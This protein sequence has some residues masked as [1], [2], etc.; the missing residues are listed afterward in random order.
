MGATSNEQP[1]LEFSLEWLPENFSAN[2]SLY[3]SCR[4]NGS[5]RAP[6]I[7]RPLSP[8][9]SLPRETIKDHRLPSFLRRENE[10]GS[11]AAW[12][13]VGESELPPLT[14]SFEPPK[15]TNSPPF[16]A[17]EGGDTAS[18]E[19]RVRASRRRK[20]RD[21]RRRP[22]PNT[23]LHHSRAVLLSP[24][25]LCLGS[26]RRGRLTRGS[27]GGKQSIKFSSNV[28]FFRRGAGRWRLVSEK[29]I[30]LES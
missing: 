28:L 17:G 16:G 27:A 13:N 24:V 21:K 22:P 18:G 20:A 9:S 29:A 26:K 7:R 1:R 19:T 14:E 5:A 4:R 10:A 15:S 23:L 30:A 6:G 3:N 25:E 12:R 8:P 11:A 2:V